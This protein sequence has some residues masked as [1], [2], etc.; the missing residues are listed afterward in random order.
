MHN[1]ITRKNLFRLPPND[2]IGRGLRRAKVNQDYH[3]QRQCRLSCSLLKECEQEIAPT[4]IHKSLNRHKGLFELVLE[5]Y[6]LWAPFCFLP[7][8]SVLPS[9]IFQ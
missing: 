7:F 9:A 8:L 2:D 5:S 3:A 4:R 1:L 6:R